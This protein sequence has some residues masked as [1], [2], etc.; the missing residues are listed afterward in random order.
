MGKRIINRQ[1][2]YFIVLFGVLLPVCMN[3]ASIKKINMA[4]F[5]VTGTVSDATPGV[6]RA[7]QTIRHTTGVELVFEPGVYHFYPDLGVDKYCFVSNNDE[8]LK[9]VVFPIEGLQN[10]TIDGQGAKFIF[11][12]N[13]NPFV[14]EKS[15]RITFR[16]F[17]VDFARSFHSEGI[18]LATRENE[19]DLEFTEQFPFRIVNNILQFTTG[20]VVGEAKT[21]V[22]KNDVFGY[23]SLLEFDSKRR[24]TA[25]M[26]YDYY[27]DAPLAAKS[28]GGNKVRIYLDGIKGTP[29]NIMVFAPNHRNYPS[30]ILTDSHDVRFEGV[31]IYH[32][33]GMG[34]IGQRVHNVTVESCKVVPAEGR[35][36]S[37]TAD[38]THFTNCTGKIEL[39]NCMFT[40]QMDDATNI[41]GI[42]V[43]IREIVSPTEIVVQLKHAQQLGFDFLS[44]GKTIEFVGSASLQT[45]GTSK[46]ASAERIN[47]NF[48]R[49]NLSESL[50]EDV[51]EGDALGE[52]RD[53]PQVHIHGNY[54]GKNRAR[55]MLLNCR[56]KTVVENNIFHSPG[57]SILFEGDA[58]FWFEQ[59]GVSDCTIRNNLF[60]NCLFGVWG[61]AIIDVAA[62]IKD[63]KEE[64]RYNRNIKIYDNTFRLFE[65]SY[66]LNLYCV[67]NLLYKNNRVEYTKDYPARLE[68]DTLFKI[69]YSDNICIQNE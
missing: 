56:G 34:I 63:K 8:G 11:H 28:L 57:A 15:T 55:G 36:V 10:I 20:E 38:A 17:S 14:V 37:C 42:Y 13:I 65:D 7:L 24:E 53:F 66:I 62:G 44:A 31:T 12:G 67:D 23:G 18:I 58:S 33:G 29:G 21:T 46:V 16:N 4:D 9:R 45:K 60:D 25:F 27:L 30:F 26:V 43:Q 54:I 64:S 51:Q 5:G 41:H 1:L 32:A 47:K 35:I 59:G 2:W 48:T 39:A 68:R 6:V 3:A 40:N 22:S 69:E 61:K 19:M 50:P 52:V 49:V